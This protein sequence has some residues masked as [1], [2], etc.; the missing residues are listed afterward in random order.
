MKRSRC[1]GECYSGERNEHTF[2][3]ILISSGVKRHLCSNQIL[4]YDYKV[5]CLEPKRDLRDSP[6]RLVVTLLAQLQALV[7][8]PNQCGTYRGFR[9][10]HSQRKRVCCCS[11]LPTSN[12]EG[13]SCSTPNIYR[14][15][16]IVACARSSYSAPSSGGP[17][18]SSCCSPLTPAT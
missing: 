13:G 8:S 9:N 3:L 5:C 16:T 7:G 6:S 15:S 1:E 10:S 4:V 12:K 18:P 14:R 11:L 2:M 17:P